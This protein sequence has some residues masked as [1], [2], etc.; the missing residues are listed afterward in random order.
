MAEHANSYLVRHRPWK[1]L[2]CLLPPP[3]TPTMAYQTPSLPHK[4][5][6][7]PNFF[8]EYSVVVNVPLKEAYTTLGTSAGHERV[9]RLSKLSTGFEL[10][11][12]D[13]VQLP[14]KA[15][16]EG[17]KLSESAVRTASVTDGSPQGKGDGM[18]ITRQHFTM[19]ETVPILFGLIKKNV[20]LRGT[21]SWSEDVLAALQSDGPQ[22][23]LD[24]PLE[25]LYE[26]ISD[27]SGGIQTWKVRRFEAVKEDPG[28]T[29]VSERIEGWSP[30]LLRPI[31]QREAE[32]GHQYVQYFSFIFNFSYSFGRCQCAHGT[33][34][35]PV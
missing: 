4:T 28:K 2:L 19:E 5:N 30:M 23:A 33:V 31:V 3:S 34:S 27:S 14:V 12:K 18:K 25:A 9:C 10:L 17:K 21:L 22:A 6:P 16:P 20:M 13:V 1:L 8:S 24:L 35:Y 7:P 32:Q 11:E 29:R 26:T 15:H